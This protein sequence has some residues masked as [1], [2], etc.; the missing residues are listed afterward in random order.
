MDKRSGVSQRLPISCLENVISNA[1][2]RSILAGEDHVVARVSDI[3]A[4]LPA[5]TGKIELEYEGELKGADNIARDLIRQAVQ[6]VFRHYFPATDFKQV[7]E[8]FDLGG[9]I[10][11]SDVEPA[12][13]MLSRLDAVRGL[14][15]KID[16]LGAM[17]DSPPALRVSA[18]EMILE[19]LYSIEKVSRSEER[20]FAA[21][22]RKAS[23]ELYR[24]YTAERNRYKKP[25][26]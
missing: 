4:A 20:G 14:L 6:M 8:W 25:L 24:D 18:G 13:A 21:P 10:K 16:A 12:A 22:D 19:G 26:N 1:E 15:D 2:R 7:I 5:I 9:N 3:Y 11:L 23:Q 17:A